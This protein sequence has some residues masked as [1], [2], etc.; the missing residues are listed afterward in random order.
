M[1]VLWL[2]SWYPNNLSPF[3]GDFIKRHAEAVSLYEEVQVIYVVRDERRELANDIIKEELVHGNLGES[4]VY[5]ATSSM[6]IPFVGKFLS[7]QKYKAVNRNVIN[8]YIRKKGVPDL[9]H[10]HVGMKAGIIAREIRKK[11]GTAYV[12]SEHWTGFLA[13]AKDQFSALPWYLRRMWRKVMK[14]AKGYS[15]VSVYLGRAL[16]RTFGTISP[17]IIPNVVN[18]SVFFPSGDSA[19]GNTFIHISNL[20][21]FKNPQQILRAF[22]IVFESYPTAELKIFGSTRAAIVQLAKDLGIESRVFF[23]AEV[24]QQVLAEQIRKSVALVLYS[25]YETFGCVVAEANACGVP[26]IVSDIPVFHE[27]VREGVNGY[28]AMPNDADA[29]ATTMKTI[30]KNRSLFNSHSIALTSV[31]KYNYEVV[32]KQFSD[33]YREVTQKS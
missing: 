30:L 21:D 17:R 18:T 23:H 12:V 15:A 25:H 20:E 5:Y 14:H 26:V 9:V 7:A 33:W 11:Y 29:L 28:F 4:I 19:E 2:V 22:K 31:S 6:R 27:T 24:P 13:E 32:G 8:E 10:V 3:N 16:E 1:K